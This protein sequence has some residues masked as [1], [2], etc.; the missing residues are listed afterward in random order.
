MHTFFQQN[1]FVIHPLSDLENDAE[2]A[3]HLVMF[4][5]STQ[6]SDDGVWRDTSTGGTLRNTCHAL[7]SLHLLGLE[8]SSGALEAGIAWLVNLSDTFDTPVGDDDTIRLYPSRFKTLAWL[9]RFRN[10]QLILDFEHLEQRL[11]QEGLIRGVMANQILATIIYADCL[12]FLKTQSTLSQQARLNL[13]QTL[14]CIKRNFSLWFEDREEDSRQSQFNQI[15]VGDLSYAFDVLLRANRLSISDEIS[16]Q[17]CRIMQTT[18]EN[19]TDSDPISTDALYCAIQ[20]SSHFAQNSSTEKV[21]KGFIRHLRI[22]YERQ[23]LQKAPL[24]FHTLVLRVL[25]THHQ[26]ELK[27]ELTRLMLNRERRRLEL[28]RESLDQGLKDDFTTLIKKRFNVEISDMQ[29]LTGGITSAKLFRVNYA[30]NLIPMD[31]MHRVQLN[32]RSSLVIKS[33]SLDLLQRSIDAYRN[34]PAALK[35]YFAQHAGEPQI[36]KAA[37][38]SPCYLIMEDLTDL[39]TFRDVMARLD[40]GILSDRQKNQ[41]RH[42]C[43]VICNQ[44]FAI[45]DTTRRD[46]SS[47]FGAQLSRLYISD[48]ERCLIKISH[49]NK[50][51][52][53]KSW[54]RGFHLG[55]RKYPSIEHYLRKIESHKARL[56]VPYL[57]L[58]HGDC[59]SRN[60]MLNDEFT[61]FKLIDLDHLNEDG[62]YILDVGRLIEDVSVFGYILKDDYRYHLSETKIVFPSDSDDPNV[63]ENRIEYPSFTTEAVRLFQQY[64]LEHI[65]IH[66]RTID[67]QFWKERLWLAM[68]TNLMSLVVQQTNKKYATVVYVEAIKLLDELITSLDEQVSLD[69]IPFPGQ[70]PTG[71]VEKRVSTG[72]MTVPA[73]HRRDSILTK[74]HKDVMELDSAIKFK[75]ASGGKVARYFVGQSSQPFA[76]IDFKKYPP[77]ILLAC[78]PHNLDDP[79]GLAES[80]PSNSDLQTVLKTLNGINPASVLYLIRQTY[81]LQN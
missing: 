22:R 35:R 39:Y 36:L 59:H 7:E 54:F 32:S 29:R 65:Q 53:L 76:V 68:A 77:S 33:G 34:L 81:N 30:L 66:A 70:H 12:L 57:S 6:N 17:A 8:N 27:A 55:N 42:A 69:N 40:R 37:S 43:D 9:D 1:P 44:L 26:Q 74:I 75:L 79:H 49:P 20:L 80:R 21:V 51:P 67:D 10:S 15:D 24:F 46:A 3:L 45:Y 73:W 61:E 72:Q 14:I 60:I 56:Q 78:Q 31:D 58:T 52:H 64:M 11:D 62:D 5:L 38:D 16:Q 28:R 13:E 19:A 47:F 50:F 48:I 63:I 71:V 23:E 18:V 25:A 2:L 4:L 41:L